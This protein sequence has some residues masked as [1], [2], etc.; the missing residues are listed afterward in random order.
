MNMVIQNEQ[1]MDELENDLEDF[2]TLDEINRINEVIRG[3]LKLKDL[4]SEYK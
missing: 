2:F 4:Q 3:T 1:L